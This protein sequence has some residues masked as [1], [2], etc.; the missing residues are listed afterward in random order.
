MNNNEKYKFSIILCNNNANSDIENTLNSIVSQDIGF[1]NIQVILVGNGSKRITEICSE[2]SNK[3]NNVEYI[4]CNN[5]T[6]GKM[7]NAA[8]THIKGRYVNF[9]EPGASYLPDSL[10][11]V[12]S[13][14]KERE[15]YLSLVTVPMYLLNNMRILPRYNGWLKPIT[16]NIINTPSAFIY[17]IS[18]S[19]FKKSVFNTVNFV[20]DK[21][22][23][24]DFLFIYDFYHYDQKFACCP[25]AS[26]ICEAGYSPVA[27]Y[28]S[29]NYENAISTIENIVKKDELTDFEKE[30]VF[31][32][33]YLIL[34]TL[35]KLDFDTEQ[36]YDNYLGRI[37]A[38][39]SK[40]DSGYIVNNM[41]CACG[42]LINYKTVLLNLK[43]IPIDTPFVKDYICSNS[44]VK[45][46]EYK[47]NGNKLSF[48]MT[49]N[50]YG[51][52]NL[53]LCAVNQKNEIIENAPDQEDYDSEL[54]HNVF[55]EFS[56]SRQHFAR[57]DFDLDKT[58]QIKF[59]FKD[60]LTNMFYPAVSCVINGRLP[61]S[62]VIKRAYYKDYS[63]F[64]KK[65]SFYIK[66]QKKLK[67]KPGLLLNR[68]IDILRIV[69]RKKII[70]WYRFI[71]KE[72]KKYILVNDRVI[73]G[74][75]NGEAL[76]KYIN[77]YDKKLAKYTYFVVD[78]ESEDYKRLKKYGKV[79]AFGSKKHKRLF[80]NARF[81]YSSHIRP[82]FFTAF[83][84]YNELKYYKDLLKQEFVWL[85]HGITMN[86]IT[87]D[88]YSKRVDY[89]VSSTNDECK[90]LSSKKYLYKDG[91]IILTG[92]SR[93]DYL[94][95][96][97]ENII[98][99]APTWRREL[100]IHK[101][102]N[103][104]LFENSNYY[105]H[106]EALLTDERLISKARECGYKID[107][108][109]HPEMINYSECFDKYNNDVVR[110]IHPKNVNYSAIFEKSK[111][112][113]TD[114]SSTLFDFAYLKK[115]EI[116]YQ[117]DKDEFF[118]KH[119]KKG[120]FDYDTDA[121]GDILKTPDEVI[122]KIM[123]YFDNDFK[124]EQK[125]IDRVNNTFRYTDNNNSKRIIDV[126]YYKKSID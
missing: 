48:L 58:R 81:I 24:E 79:V 114:Y 66:K 37:V 115:P 53:K 94:V 87:V 123:F 78:K 93:Y 110:I 106:Y 83:D 19:F 99:I 100:G 92:F 46:Q 33:L 54:Y 18:S 49:Y 30:F 96:N 6:V 102:I 60:E 44:S 65:Q 14:F 97:A 71:N 16:R 63:L 39:L 118:G 122:D 124:M 107:F 125:Y 4:C 112:F 1:D 20:E 76:F 68:I 40:F 69:G 41:R 31:Y 90:E 120:Y 103:Y 50:N 8:L 9:I 55:G 26:Y 28:G 17:S 21:P 85:Q 113:I 36:Q 77:K 27:Q 88:Y 42:G 72:N 47:F 62:G 3:Y 80:I 74:G 59:V 51:Y 64:Y 22:D 126:T 95:N 34:L 23:E 45:L 73:K 11:E 38:V 116:L 109:L 75:D 5:A 101:E 119:Y 89:V 13:F 32:R 117:F 82:E 35:K 108:V 84:F 7:R 70:P 98:T 91:Q 61:I 111:L 2:W 121:F 25:D 67:G 56:L 10:S 57:F 105:K 52:E 12:Y 86:G 104:A 15:V 43:N 29:Q